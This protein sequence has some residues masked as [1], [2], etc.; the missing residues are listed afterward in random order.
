M[1]FEHFVETAWSEHADHPGAVAERLEASLALVDAPSRVAPF[2]RLVTHVFGEH[3]G[4]WRRGSIL[5]EA[6]RDR[7]RDDDAAAQAIARGVATL[8]YAAGDATALDGLSEENRIAALSAASSVFVGRALY[9]RALDTY[10]Q[11]LGL[12]ATGLPDGSPALRALA[13]GGNNL[14]ATL[15]SK[16]DRNADE[17]RGMVDAARA[18]LVYW[19]RAGTWLE[20]ERAE[21]L[22]A[23]SFLS[24]RQPGEAAVHASRCVAL[25]ERHDAPA[26]E[27]FFGCVALALAERDLGD[28]AAFESTRERARALATSLA[29]DERDACASALE[30]IGDR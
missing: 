8:A 2:A 6:L 14:A 7:A 24:A 25:C 28:A 18:S 23:R 4:E 15:E 27:R 10:A 26:F 13:V 3:L 12:A 21:Y 1:S 11:A 29:A 30:E 19:K 9:S 22:L 20:E 5:L 16:P 17:T